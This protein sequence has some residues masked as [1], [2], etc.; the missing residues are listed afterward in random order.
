MVLKILVS[1]LSA[2]FQNFQI[3]LKFFLSFS[4][5][6]DL[7][8]PMNFFKACR[9]NPGPISERKLVW[10]IFSKQLYLKGSIFAFGIKASK[11]LAMIVQ[12]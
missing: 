6:I 8:G 12:F 4:E 10:N 5:L 3:I 9:Y 11:V 1:R 7:Q 2:T